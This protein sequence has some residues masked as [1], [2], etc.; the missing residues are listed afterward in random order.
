MDRY[1]RRTF[2]RNFP[3][4]CVLGAG[5]TAF[6]VSSPAERASTDPRVIGH[7][8]C[9]A[10]LPENTLEAVDRAPAVADAIEVDLRRA[11]SGE[12]VVIHDATVDRVTDGTGA[13]ADRSLEELRSLSV[14][15]TGEPVPTLEE[16][17]E[18]VPASVGLVLDLK[19][20]GI[21]SDVD[22]LLAAFDRDA[23]L[24]S[25]SPSILREVRE[26]GRES[27][28]ILREPWLGRRFRAV[29]ARTSV[30]IYPRM[31]VDQWLTTAAEL[32]CVAIHP[33]FELCL[34]TDLVERAHDRGLRVEPWTITRSS[35]A[36]R[37]RSLG[38]DGLISDICSPLS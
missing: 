23:L 31:R 15:E 17:L 25:F 35:E 9:A 21:A 33:R 27:A 37:L 13:V 32:D 11:S 6:T 7:R 36:A 12:I 4:A 22:E 1:T 28:L 2:L 3:V 34:R 26:T 19:V 38:V 29:V 10:E 24:S 20:E 16:V 18:T 5:T 30:P 8:G 14:L